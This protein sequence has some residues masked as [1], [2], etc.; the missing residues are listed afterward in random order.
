MK[1]QDMLD[2]DTMQLLREAGFDFAILNHV[3]L[4]D[5]E[6]VIQTA[7]AAVVEGRNP[8]TVARNFCRSEARHH[9]RERAG[10]MH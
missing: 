7:T 6:D 9:K 10:L 2:R 1:H 5:A 4:D 8:N 3:R